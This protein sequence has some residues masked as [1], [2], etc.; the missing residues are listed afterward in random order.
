M[1]S[2]LRRPRRG[3]PRSCLLLPVVCAQW[4]S[5]KAAPVT[6]ILSF[7]NL[8]FQPRGFNNLHCNDTCWQWD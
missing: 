3:K 4:P 1:R 2:V 6:S 7:S 8:R 5:A